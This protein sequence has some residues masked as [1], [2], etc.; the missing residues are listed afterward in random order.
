MNGLKRL[1]RD[2]GGAS[3]VEYGIL[4]AGVAGVI[5]LVVWVIGEKVN[6]TLANLVNQL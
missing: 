6:N 5:M 2:E 4:V 3:A 1:L